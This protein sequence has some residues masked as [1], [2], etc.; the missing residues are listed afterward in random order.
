VP[1]DHPIAVELLGFQTKV[2]GAVYNEAIQLDEG[3]FVQEQIE[4]LARR[5]LPFLVLCLE[6]RFAAAL[7]GLRSAALQKVE[8]LSHGHRSEKLTSRG[9]SI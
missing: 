2:G 4:P 5:E 3:A 7:L 8:L 1:G 9:M 6:A